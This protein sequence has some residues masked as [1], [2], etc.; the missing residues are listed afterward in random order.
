MQIEHGE[1][2]A[3]LVMKP[4]CLRVRW[5][6]IVFGVQKPVMNLVWLTTKQSLLIVKLMTL[7]G[8][9]MAT[10]DGRDMVG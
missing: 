8:G 10:G 4:S 1:D 6:C 3:E 9:G 5:P 7:M 2:F